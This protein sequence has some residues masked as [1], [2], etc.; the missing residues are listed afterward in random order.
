MKASRTQFFG[1]NLDKGRFEYSDKK[2]V[3]VDGQTDSNKTVVICGFETKKIIFKH[4]M[5]PVST[6][7]SKNVTVRTAQIK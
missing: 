5:K 4:I 3:K 6:N 1:L 2:Y 7:H